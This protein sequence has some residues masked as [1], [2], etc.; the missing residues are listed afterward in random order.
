MRNG[1]MVED[2]ALRVAPAP[3]VSGDV[4]PR[5]ELIQL[6]AGAWRMLVP[7][8]FVERV[9]GAAL[10]AVRPSEDGASAPVVAI[11]Q[12]L[13]PVLF[14]E[15]LLGATEVPLDAS[16]QMVLLRQGARR[17]LL[18][19]DAVEEVVEAEPVPAPPDAAR[20]SFVAAFSGGARPLAV[21]DVPRLLEL[22]A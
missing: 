7:M 12:A 20:R 1:I 2:V 8:R 3:P 6:R 13:V 19:V 18:W 5:E 10:P 17:A 4:I 14:A 9:L 16:D 15:A 11:G 21:L 22:A